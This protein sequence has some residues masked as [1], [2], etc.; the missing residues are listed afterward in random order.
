MLQ[1]NSWGLGGGW[2]REDN[3]RAVVG[4]T[5]NFEVKTSRDCTVLNGIIAILTLLFRKLQL[6]H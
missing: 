1:W 5:G 6:K 2:E 3:C 4:I